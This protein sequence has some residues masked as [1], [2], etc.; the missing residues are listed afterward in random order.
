MRKLFG[1]VINVI[2]M[3]TIF[4]RLGLSATEYLLVNNGNSIA[5]SATFYKLNTK[6][7]K[8]SKT[9]V[10]GTG[11]QGGLLDYVAQIEQAISN[12]AGCIFVL[13]DGSSDISAFSK[14]TTYKRVGRY[15]NSQLIAGWGGGTLALAPNMRFLYASYGES[16]YIGVWNVNSDCTLSLSSTIFDGDLFG[17]I[18][19][20]PNGKYVVG[21]SGDSTVKLFAVGPD[22]SLTYVGNAFLNI[23]LCKRVTYCIARGIDVT[24]D[25]RFVVVASSS[26]DIRHQYAIPVAVTARITAKGLSNLRAWPLKNSAGLAEG[27]FPF[28]GATGYGGSGPLYFGVMEVGGYNPGVLTVN[29]VEKPMSFTVTNA[30][31]VSPSVADIAVTGN[32]MVIAQNPDQISVFRIKKDGSLKLLSTT[33]IDE[34]GEGLF[35]LSIFPNTR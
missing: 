26:V 31:V 13:N 33:T 18:K 15:F 14:G 7:G 25:S 5:N 21:S 17:P 3:I 2:A 24:K 27:N 32:T 8:L 23:G 4:C 12:D 1:K 10:L 34:P 19:I 20:T 6:T 11:G 22:G 28:F 9:A 35:S 29:F 16:G 30:T